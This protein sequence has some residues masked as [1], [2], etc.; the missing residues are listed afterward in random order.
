[1]QPNPSTLA[2]TRMQREQ[3]A[4]GSQG[5]SPYTVLTRQLNMRHVSTNLLQLPRSANSSEPQSPGPQ[6]LVMPTGLAA[7]STAAVATGWPANLE[8]AVPSGASSSRSSR[9]VEKM[10]G[11]LSEAREASQERRARPTT[12]GVKRQ[13]LLQRSRDAEFADFSGLSREASRSKESKSSSKESPT[14]SSN[15]VAAAAQLIA[16]VLREPPA[17]GNPLSPGL[18]GISRTNLS[19]WH[20]DL[21]RRSRQGDSGDD[22][23]AASAENPAAG[24]SRGRLESDGSHGSAGPTMES[25]ET[26]I[27]SA[28]AAVPASSSS[29]RRNHAFSS[30]PA[31]V[32]A[33]AGR[34]L[35]S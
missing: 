20:D 5:A 15:S 32:A 19:P 13:P 35:K 21:P 4:N 27:S 30:S 7:Y 31:A 2:M 29:R 22:S 26:G 9:V 8:K 25:A 24:A 34:Y 10:D 16:E 6:A 1:M 33:R 14:G 17:D 3:K 12:A 18:R 28:A 23:G 11:S